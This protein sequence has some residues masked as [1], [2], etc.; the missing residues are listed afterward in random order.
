MYRKELL[1]TVGEFREELFGEMALRL[2][3]CGM[4]RVSIEV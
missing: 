1:P 3:E 4:A 2:D